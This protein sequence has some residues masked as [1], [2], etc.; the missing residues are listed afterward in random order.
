M[1]EHVK[2]CLSESSQKQLRIVDRVKFLETET[3]IDIFMFDIQYNKDTFVNKSIV[4]EKR[5]L[6]QFIIHQSLIDE[7]QAPKV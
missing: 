4:D 5:K 2:T 1:S 3:P 7:L 6:G